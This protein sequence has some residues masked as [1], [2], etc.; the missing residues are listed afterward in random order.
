MGGTLICRI[1]GAQP[2]SLSTNIDSAPFAARM[3]FV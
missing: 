3:L 1:R 2:C